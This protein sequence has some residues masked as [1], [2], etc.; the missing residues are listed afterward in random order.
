MA[1]KGEVGINVLIGLSF[2]IIGFFSSVI[3]FMGF[4]LEDTRF[5]FIGG[6]LMGA[7]TLIIS[8][9]ERFIK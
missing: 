7:L 8:V 3:V 2:L 6:L 5:T 4:V 9:M 1:K